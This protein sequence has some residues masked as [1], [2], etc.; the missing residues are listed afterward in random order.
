MASQ[1]F[2]CLYVSLSA[3]NSHDP[4]VCQTIYLHCLQVPNGSDRCKDVHIDDH[5]PS[6]EKE[7]E[8]WR[9]WSVWQ[10]APR[11]R[12]K[13]NKKKGRA[14][15]LQLKSLAV[16]LSLFIFHAKIMPTGGS[17]NGRQQQ[18]RHPEERSSSHN[19]V[20]LIIPPSPCTTPDGSSTSTPDPINPESDQEERQENNMRW[21]QLSAD[22]YDESPVWTR[23]ATGLDVPGAVHSV[24]TPSTQWPLTRTARDPGFQ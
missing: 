20:A 8:K 4:P 7:G 17:V 12:G 9:Y 18:Q 16:F 21:L 1:L 24:V 23:H 5:S 6:W 3:I 22:P 15:M 19:Y 2:V 13:R 10:Q 11:W 14:A